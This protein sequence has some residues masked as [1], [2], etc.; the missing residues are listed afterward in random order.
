[1]YEAALNEDEE[2]ARNLVLGEFLSV[3][4]S[5]SLHEKLGEQDFAAF[6]A[7]SIEDFYDGSYIRYALVNALDLVAFKVQKHWFPTLLS[8]EEVSHPSEVWAGWHFKSLYGAMYLQ[9]YW[10]MAAGGSVTR[11]RYCGR[12][13]SLASPLSGARKPRQ[14][15][16]S[17]TMPAAR[18]TTTTR[19]RSPSVRVDYRSPSHWRTASVSLRV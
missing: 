12:I 5:P 15:K 4:P 1:M 3:G 18:D 8:E 2:A 19:R 10:L 7:E 16:K 14:D 6:L 13:I 9:M 17:A 11:C